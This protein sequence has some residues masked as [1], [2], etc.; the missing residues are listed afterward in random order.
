[1]NIS[2]PN[3][4]IVTLSP[5][6]VLRING[7]RFSTNTDST[8]AFY[9]S[10][11]GCARKT[12]CRVSSSHIVKSSDG[13]NI[14]FTI[15]NI[16]DDMYYVQVIDKK[17]G[18]SNMMELVITKP[19]ATSINTV[20]MLPNS[21][22]SVPIQ[23]KV[24]PTVTT[25]AAPSTSYTTP[26]ISRISPTPGVAGTI[27]TIEGVNFEGVDAYT[28]FFRNNTGGEINPDNVVVTSTRITFKV[29]N[30]T[31][32]TYSVSLF[33]DKGDSNTVNFTITA[34]QTNTSSVFDWFLSFFK[35]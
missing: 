25:V 31:Y 28:I 2:S 13:K 14:D 17:T 3:Q 35:F 5:G 30:I 11:Q 29:P 1:M 7:V 27:V 22:T 9:A 26:H 16:F 6:D 34:P 4:K 23:P 24:V 12:P 21:T 15:P 20:N 8:I 19:K 32:G 10:N 33:G 18:A